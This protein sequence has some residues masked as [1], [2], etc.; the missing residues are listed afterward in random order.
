M[1]PWMPCPADLPL[2]PMAPL[3][4]FAPDIWL[5]A[6][7]LRFFGLETGTRMTIV[8]L[9][10]GGLFV[11]SPVALDAALRETV[12]ALGPVAA[13]VAPSLF[14]HLYVGDWQRAYPDAAFFACPGLL[15]KRPDLAFHGVLG[16]EPHAFWRD[17]FDQLFFSANSLANEVLFFHRPTQTIV[18]ADFVLDLGSHPSR[19]TRAAARVLGPSGPGVTWL[20]R[21]MIGRRKEARGQVD[22]VLAWQA[23]RLLIAHGGVIGEGATEVVRR[24]FAWV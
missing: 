10:N 12:D 7:P 11:H 15:K 16:D 24:A 20:E 6:R 13:V 21:A 17:D 22:R 9:A 2:L 23:K 5:E 1:A 14:H 3:A 4:P 18:S 8:R 19:L